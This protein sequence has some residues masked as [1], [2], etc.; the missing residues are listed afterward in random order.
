MAPVVREL[1][2]RPWAEVS[3]VLTS[4]HRHL[5]DPLLAR[6]G[7]RG[8]LDLDLM[9]ENQ[10]L[11]GLTTRL[12]ERLPSVLEAERPHI[13]VA[14]GDTTT[15]LATAMSC[16]YLG[17]P[18]AHVEAGLRSG[19]LQQPFPEEFNRIVADR[20][21]EVHFAPT[22]AARAHL[23]QEGIEPDRIHITGNTVIDALLWMAERAPPLHLP[24][25][26]DQRLM[27]MTLHRRES[28]G[29]PMRSV[30]AAV[31][32]LAKA[33]PD[34]DVVYPVHPNPN[35]RGPAYEYLGNLDRV[36]LCDPL[37]YA[38]LVTT[39]KRSHLVLTDSGGIQEEAPAL[40]KPVLVTRETTER[41]EAIHAGVARLVG[42]DEDC[43]VDAVQHLL[44]HP[45]AYTAM[46]RGISP[47]GDGRAAERIADRL[48]ETFTSTDSMCILDKI[49]ECRGGAMGRTGYR[50]PT[51]GLG[52]LGSMV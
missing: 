30:F 8:D 9:Q 40:G 38:Q 48:R 1:R 22:A 18:F 7:I 29:E 14:Q 17:I 35:V 46:A 12:L 23:L 31:R 15:V 50:R 47:Y 28:F 33:N 43:I 3:V 6:F 44:D 49:D 10:S 19:D 51:P 39:L 42:T 5:V 11:A 25:P 36:H 27:L 2:A 52:R 37:D 13:V 32:R 20:L 16:F 45:A 24:I 4:Q 21:A 26:D 41:P 34:L